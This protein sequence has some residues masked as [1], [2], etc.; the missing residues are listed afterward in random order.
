MKLVR[1]AD[2]IEDGTAVLRL[3]GGVRWQAVHQ[4][5][6]YDPPHQFVDV[7]R[8]PGL[9]SVVPWRHVHRFEDTGSSGTRVVDRVHTR[10]PGR[11][12]EPVFAYRAAQLKGDFSTHRAM[13]ELHDGRLTVAVTGSSGLVG[14]ALTAL[15]RTGGHRVIALVRR[16]PSGP[17]ERYWDTEQP[18][19]NLLDGVDAVIHLAG[20]SIAG[21]FT[22]GHRHAVRGSR[23]GPTRALAA[24]VGDRPFVCAS[25][26]GFYGTDA[27]ADVPLDETA[28][29]GEGFLAEVVRDW[30]DA[31]HEASGRVVTV[32]TG[33]VLSSKGGLLA[34]QW[35]LFA[36][37]LGGPLGEGTQ[38]MSWIGL[39]D[40]IDVYYR[41]LFDARVAGPVNAVTPHPVNGNGYAHT[42]ARVLHRPALLRVPPWG[43]RVL[44]G[45]T[46]ARELALASQRLDPGV[47][48]SVGH[49]FRFPRLESLL[50]HELGKTRG[51]RG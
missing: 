44:L 23:I 8:T 6:D 47:L 51:P 25:A 5:R 36:A 10:V 34:V 31:A 22:D 13:R 2:S 39:D 32:R 24:L 15:L 30:E 33:L 12:L 35:P 26:V 17:D 16:P 9:R 28:P 1:E 46:G 41:A 43:P 37:G 19:D 45:E 18:A 11:V 14:G 27:A 50:R 4:A 21:R 38:W 20:A 3:P 48:A 42:L 29:P 40:L 7:L 49:A